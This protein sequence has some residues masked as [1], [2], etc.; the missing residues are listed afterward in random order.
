[1]EEESLFRQE[2]LQALIDGAQQQLGQISTGDHLELSDFITI[3]E[4]EPDDTVPPSL[5][6]TEGI[7]SF[8]V[9]VTPVAI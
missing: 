6:A 3:S 7:G 4:D 9:Q 2:V 5:G 1:M 8:W